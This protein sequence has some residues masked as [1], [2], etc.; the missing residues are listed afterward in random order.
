VRCNVIAG[1]TPAQWASF[2]LALLIALVGV[3][4][5]VEARRRE[6]K[7]L[8]VAEAKD[9]ATA[10]E[11]V[12]TDLEAKVGAAHEHARKLGESMRD[13]PTKD[14]MREAI[15][16]MEKSV[17]KDIGHVNAGVSDIKTL[18]QTTITNQQRVIAG[19]SR[20]PLGRSILEPDDG[21]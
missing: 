21:T 14:D 9:R 1:S 16:A 20:S 19:M 10:L 6:A 12:K 5:Y 8:V 13:Y 4:L 15:E 7:D 17:G 3:V 18:L 2:L 11:K